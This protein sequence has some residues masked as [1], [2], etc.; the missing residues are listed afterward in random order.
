MVPGSVEI[1]NSE[2]T[3]FARESDIALAVLALILCWEVLGCFMIE[4][5]CSGRLLVGSAC[6]RE[7]LRLPSSVGRHEVGARVR[8]SGLANGNPVF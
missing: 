3:F 5:E 8:G 7:R 4:M 1:A 2:Q 6:L